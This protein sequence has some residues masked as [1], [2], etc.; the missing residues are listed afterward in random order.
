MN[1]KDN[2]KKKDLKEKKH[3]KMESFKSRELQ[4]LIFSAIGISLVVGSSVVL[5][6]NFPIVVGMIY[7]I[8]EEVKNRK[9]SKTK[10]KQSLKRLAKR[11]LLSIET[12]GG[13][14][15]VKI[16]EKGKTE[17]FRYSLRELLDHKKKNKK[18]N[19]KWFLVIFDVPEKERKKRDYLRRFLSTI[20]F[21]QYQKSVYVYPYECQKEIALVKRIVEGGKYMQYIVA[22]EIEDEEKIKRAFFLS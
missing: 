17:V 10:I 15:M 13:D 18:W 12:H 8:I 4:Q 5:T 3:K 20:G 1:E 7:K 19:G 11:Q 22:E 6:P 21:F 2:N 9:V 14:A 16:L